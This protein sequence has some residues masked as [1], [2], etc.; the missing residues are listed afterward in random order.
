MLIVSVRLGTFSH[1]YNVQKMPR[2][3]KECNLNNN[4][5]QNKV[6]IVDKQ[7]LHFSDCCLNY[8][9]YSFER[10][11]KKSTVK[12]STV[13]S[14][15]ETTQHETTQHE[16]T[17]HETIQYE[18][19]YNV[20]IVKSGRKAWGTTSIDND[21]EDNDDVQEGEGEQEE[22]NLEDEILWWNVEIC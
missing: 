10:T 18:S 12:K 15:F 3:P 2:V 11:V 6:T 7:Q 9:E 13:K 20:F 4:F 16:T 5:P 19:T 1:V 14:S 17:Q 21:D 8:Q 22:A